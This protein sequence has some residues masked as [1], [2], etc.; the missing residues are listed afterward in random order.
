MTSLKYYLDPD[1]AHAPTRAHDGD[2][3]LDLRVQRHLTVA[4]GRTVMTDTGVHVAVPEGHVGLVFI[5]SSVGAKR[6]VHLANGTGVIDS[7]YRGSIGLA[8]HNFGRYPVTFSAGERVAQLV[9]L[10]IF[11]GPDVQVDRLDMLGEST[12]GHGGFGSTGRG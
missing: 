6:K 11:T 2:A 8:L 5:R 10:P 12:R 4:C 3:G 1:C 7:G 9:I